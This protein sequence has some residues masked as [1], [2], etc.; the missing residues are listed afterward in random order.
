MILFNFKI[1]L[2]KILRN[3]EEVHEKIWEVLRKFWKQQHRKFDRNISYGWGS[4]QKFVHHV[5]CYHKVIAKPELVPFSYSATYHL[6]H[7]LTNPMVPTGV[8]VAGATAPNPIFHWYHHTSITSPYPTPSCL[9]L[10]L[11]R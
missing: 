8:C 7:A 5:K 10:R 9:T 6:P 1:I 3:V 4:F 2:S 11:P